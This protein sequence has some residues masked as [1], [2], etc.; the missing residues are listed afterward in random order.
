MHC[1]VRTDLHQHLWTA[2]LWDALAARSAPPRLRRDGEGWLLELLGEPPFRLGA[3]PDDSDRRAAQLAAEGLDV[4]AVALSTALGI[5][6][7]PPDE[8]RAIVAAWHADADELPA[9]LSAWGALALTD[10]DPAEVDALLDR[11]RIGLCLPANALATPA[12]LDDLGPVLARLEARN[13]PLFV[14]PGPAAPGS[15]LP[16]LTD[17]VASLNAAWHAFALHGR[18]SHPTLRVLFAA[19]AGL[20]PLHVERLAA[21]GHA[22]G[23]RAAL[24]DDRLFYDT[25]SYGPLAIDQVARVADPG[26]L[27]HGSDWPYADPR[28]PH[29]PLTRALLEA[30][31]AAL[32]RGRP[33]AVAA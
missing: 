8:A 15:F 32:L 2:G 16:P 17:Y 25:S 27:V 19:L 22:A 30:N 33:A 5:E 11:G 31:P 24:A 21:R 7:L 29:A 18:R 28:L 6:H 23:A 1:D 13:A 20:A 9:R 3:G 12:L 26:S 14:H 4:A 10:A